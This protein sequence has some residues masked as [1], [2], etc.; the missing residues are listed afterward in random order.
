MAIQIRRR[1]FITLLGGAAAAWPLAAHAQQS[2]MPVIGFLSGR[3][4]GESESVEAAFRQ[5]LKESGYAEGQNVHIAFR[6]A[7]GRYDRLPALVAS[8]VDIRVAVIA[9]AGGQAVSLAAKAATSTIP[10]VFVSGEDPVKLGLVATLNRPGGSATGVSMFLSEMEAKRF[11]LLHEL[12]PTATMIG[13]IV[14]PSSP[15]IDT[16]LREINSAARALGR[17]IQ[18]VNATN[19]RELDAAFAS[20]AQS[21]AGA[22]LIAANA[23][24]TS[25]RDQIVALAA[26]R[27]IP[28][29]Y[30]QREF[31]MAGGLVSYG[32]NLSDSYRL[33]GVYTGK[34]LKGEKPT[35]LPVQRSTK[36]ELVINLKT[37]KALGL[38]VPPALSARADE[39]IE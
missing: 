13:V 12:V 2:T 24:F 22:L 38:D 5:G 16:Q 6:W 11:A 27:A 30:D 21:K 10:I 35:D 31:P 3:S 20:L 36:F 25:R 19:E 26:Q 18:I 37:A 7:E 28:A 1:D 33:M 39:V 4:P 32:T 8:L 9:A 14:N 34:I 17:Q 15:S 23:Y 29:I